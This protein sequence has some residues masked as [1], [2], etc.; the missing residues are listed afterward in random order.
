M[1]SMGFYPDMREMQ[2]YLPSRQ[3]HTCM[4][5]ATFPEAVLRTAREFI[6]EGEFLSLSADHI[7]V[8]DTEHVFYLVDGMD[9][10]RSLV[11]LIEVENPTSA[12]IFCNTKAQV[13]YVCVVLQRFG[14]DADEL[15]ADLSQSERE[16]VLDRVRKGTLRFLVATDVAA[17]GLDIEHISHVINYDIPLEAESYVH[18]IGRTGRAGRTGIAITLVTPR[19]RRLWQVI[20][21]FTGASIQR[22]HLPTISDVITR[23]REAFKETLRDIIT[24]GGL[25]TYQ[26][27]AEELGEEF[28]PTD[29]AA[30]AFKLL[31]GDQPDDVEDKLA[32]ME[33]PE[34]TSDKKF[35]SRR[36]ERDGAGPERGMTRLYINVGREDGVRPADIVGAIANEAEIPGRSIGAIEIYD[37]FTLVDVP[38]NHTERVLK[39]LKRTMIRNHKIAP[40]IAK[41]VKAHG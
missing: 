33:E 25:E 18:R 28:S 22:L 9:K 32:Q 17:R 27:M 26:I 16:R 14:Y 34:T 15:S 12:I 20:Q 8:T 10:D 7:H 39:A 4:F 5:S 13:H 24:Q 2:R 3:I 6:H 1:L 19:E 38:S 31:L 11:R 41:P 23:R 36:R 30:A 40:S 21:R 29:L 37:R 35:S